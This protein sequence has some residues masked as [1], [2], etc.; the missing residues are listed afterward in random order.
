MYTYK[1]YEENKK[2]NNNITE[3]M[4]RCFLILNKIFYD[5]RNPRTI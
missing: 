1:K 5:N 4:W 3:K 2:H